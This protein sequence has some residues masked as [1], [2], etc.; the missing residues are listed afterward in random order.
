MEE[1]QGEGGATTSAENTVNG[2]H[3]YYKTE[4]LPVPGTWPLFSWALPATVTARKNILLSETGK[5][6][7][8]KEDKPAMQY[9]TMQ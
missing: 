4:R 1:A 6:I 3:G 9:S 7:N 8:N 5:Q 2:P